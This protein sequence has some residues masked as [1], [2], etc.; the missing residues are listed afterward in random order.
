MWRMKPQAN[1][2]HFAVAGESE[3][4]PG[5]VGRSPLP[6][7]ESWYL[8]IPSAELGTGKVATRRLM[9]QDVVVYRTTS[10]HVRAVRAHCPHLGAHL[11]HGTV[12]GE[13]IVCPFHHFAYDANGAIAHVGPGYT[14]KPKHCTLPVLH[15]QET[16][17][18][19]FAWAGA[20]SPSWTIPEFLTSHHTPAR[21]ITY[22]VPT[23]PQEVLENGADIRH[24]LLL[25]GYSAASQPA[26]LEGHILSQDLD[27]IRPI[28]PLPP[29]KLRAEIQHHGLGFSTIRINIA[30]LGLE[31]RILVSPRPVEPWR[32]HMAIGASIRLTPPYGRE[33]ALVQRAFKATGRAMHPLVY[34]LLMRE[35]NSDFQI[36]SSKKYTNPPRIAAGEGPI[37]PFRKWA[38]QFYP[39]QPVK[40][41]NDVNDAH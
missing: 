5:Y 29:L 24:V 10:G 2:R 26:V 13:N 20:N 8:L 34:R 27:L 37:G 33:A 9:G 31:Q 21:Y 39:E 36:W 32:V 6:Y 19:I 25:H 12:Q 11:G 23:H 38:R 7:P 1:W 17:G 15:C 40:L 4:T 35:V 18:G 41:W 14:D 30:A 28:R 16:N 22:D 3:P